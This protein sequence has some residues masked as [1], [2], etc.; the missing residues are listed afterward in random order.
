MAA[1][2]TGLRAQSNR[3]SAL[4]VIVQASLRDWLTRPQ[5][6]DPSWRTSMLTALVLAGLLVFIIVFLEPS[7]TDRYQAPWRTLRLCG[8]GLCIL[9]PMLLVHAHNRWRA[10]RRDG[11]W[12]TLQS[13]QSLLLLLL[14]ILLSSYMYNVYV[15]NAR[16]P[17][18]DDALM[19]MLRIGLPYLPLLVVPGVLLQ[20][21]LRAQAQRRAQN[22]ALVWVRGHNRN[23][24][25]RLVASDVLYAQAQQ[26]YVT[27][28]HVQGSTVKQHMLRLTLVELQQQL[29]QLQR[30]HRSYLV[31]PAQVQGVA[32]NARRRRLQ[33]QHVR[34]TIPVS[35]RFDLRRLTPPDSS[36]V[37]QRLTS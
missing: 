21:R 12:T 16:Q 22:A 11:H 1:I 24:R 26:N 34:T 14:L 4:A 23:E 27:L 17:A 20:R 25:L 7:G 35:S 10:R 32:G 8:Y 19:W 5:T 13:L 36:D 3:L 15:V 28:C 33:L 9:L 37:D 29:P 30:V 31:N 6:F 2:D 18:W